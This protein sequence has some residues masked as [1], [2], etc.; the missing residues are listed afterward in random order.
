MCAFEVLGNFAALNNRRQLLEVAEHQK[1][2]A[3]ECFART[4]PV[5][6]Q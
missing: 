1:P 4:T 5:Q 3:A 2:H 6:A